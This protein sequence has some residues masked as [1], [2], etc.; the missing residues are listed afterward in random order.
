M[1]FVDDSVKIVDDMGNV[2]SPG[3]SGDM[4][5]QPMTLREGLARS[6]NT[7][8]AQLIDMIGPAQAAF[9]A[10]RMG[11]TS[12]LDEVPSLALG[13]SDVKL[14]E[15]TSAYSA[16]ANG[17]LLYEPTL[18]WRIEDRLGNLL[19]EAQPSPREA[20]SEATAYTMVDMLR[21]VIRM[22]GGS[23]VRM[24]SQYRMGDY[25]IAGKT[26]TTQNAADTWFMM[27]HPD[28]VMGSWV[29]FNDP[30]YTFRT[31]WW[32]QGAHTALH[33]VGNF[34]T[35]VTSEEDVFI[36]KDSRFP[37][38]ARFL[39]A[40]NGEMPTDSLNTVDD[41]KGRLDW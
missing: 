13:T 5:G 6:K 34:M 8:T 36:S 11:I 40:S 31:D 27:M 28:L 24:I 25:D 39:G 33:V 41:R 1:T 14:L 4:T 30:A 35:Q 29:G 20:L 16:F 9:Y 19:Y 21:A 37:T 23:G 38:P 22:Q 7:I 32:G 17:G 2:W 15:M 10:R 3:N 18:I 12:P 26:G